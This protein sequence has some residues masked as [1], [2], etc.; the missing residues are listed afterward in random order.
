[1]LSSEL[2]VILIP[3]NLFVFNPALPIIHLH[4]MALLMGTLE[5]HEGEGAELLKEVKVAQE[6]IATSFGILKTAHSR[7]VLWDKASG[8]E[9]ILILKRL[10]RLG[11]LPSALILSFRRA[12]YIISDTI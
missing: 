11:A 2:P 6:A 3:V 7:R 10:W 1:M 12:T 9:P 5:V 8:I 4:L